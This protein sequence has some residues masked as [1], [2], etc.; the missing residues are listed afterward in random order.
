MSKLGVMY[1]SNSDSW[2]TPQ[3]LFDK[4]NERYE[5]TVDVCAH[6]SNHKVDTWFGRQKDYSFIDGLEESWRGEVCFM[7]PPYSKGQQAQWLRKAAAESMSNNAITVALVP[8]RTDTVAFHETAPYCHELVFLKG[9]VNFVGGEH[10]APFPSMLMVFTPTP[11]D[12][13]LAYLWD[14]K[15]EPANW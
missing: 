11:S 5:F 6:G 8:S 3:D 1:S 12:P 4:L 7:N 13:P 2:A 9:R 10:S 15:R 14:W